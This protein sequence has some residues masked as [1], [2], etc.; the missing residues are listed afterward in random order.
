MLV[1]KEQQAR[2]LL[3]ALLRHVANLEYARAA[4]QLGSSNGVFST[5]ELLAPRCR[6]R[7]HRAGG[8]G[9]F[10]LNA[11]VTIKALT[12]GAALFT[13]IPE[14]EGQPAWR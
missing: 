9:P 4:A 6:V 2:T 5:P 11:A 3:E 8:G 7:P 13:S 14:A 12:P 10:Q 1:V